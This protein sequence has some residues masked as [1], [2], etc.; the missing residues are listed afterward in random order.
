MFSRLQ[1]LISPDDYMSPT[2]RSRFSLSNISFRI[3][4]IGCVAVA[5][6]AV[7]AATYWHIQAK[8]AANAAQQNIANQIDEKRDIVSVKSL[9]LRIND[10]NFL[11]HKDQMHLT[12]HDESM[13]VISEAL[14]TIRS[15][16]ATHGLPDISGKAVN[17]RN[18]LQLYE[19]Q[20]E[21]LEIYRV[22]LGLNEN[23]GAE[24]KLRAAVREI[25]TTLNQYDYPR[26]S[27]S[28][29]MMRRHEKDF[30][31]RLRPVF[32]EE[33]DKR[34]VEFKS[35]LADTSISRNEKDALLTRL[36]TYQ[37]AFRVWMRT[38]HAVEEARELL[39]KLFSDVEP[40]L[41]DI[42]MSIKSYERQTSQK[43]EADVA[44]LAQFMW[45]VVGV[46]LVATAILV[47]LIGRSISRP[48]GQMTSAVQQLGAGQFDVE[49]PGRGR[50][51]E[52]GLMASA[53]DLFKDKL[54]A[55]A[56]A[57][58]L[59]E[60]EQQQ[61]VAAARRK[62]AHGLADSFEA[63]VG[64]I[65]AQVASLS[66]QLAAASDELARTAELSQLASGQAASSSE[67]VS[68]SA[69][70][71]ARATEEMTSSI[72]EIDRQAAHASSVSRLV[73]DKARETEV[74]GQALL[75][76]SAKITEVVDMIRAIA[77]QTNLL[78][79]NATIEAAR[80][81]EAGRG[82]AVVAS[83]VKQLATQTSAATSTIAAYVQEM[84]AA[85]QQSVVGMNLVI[86]E[87]VSISDVSAAISVAVSQQTATTSEIARDVQYVA[88]ASHTVS[89]RIAEVGHQVSSTGA[90]AEEL[91]VSARELSNGGAQL[92]SEVDHFLRVVRA[93]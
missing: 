25:E 14:E 58:A 85:A 81:G 93:A 72:A 68:S 13:K 45:L 46:S 70:S 2:M 39:D 24:G 43:T 12:K 48:L 20:L 5:G 79:L 27:V 7:V 73:T 31:L 40:L 29:L 78:A 30:M 75:V 52:L 62:E 6:M 56:R 87:I 34:V 37:N 36:S 18:K 38:A 51:D 64:S 71:V 26:L 42:D 41:N 74:R 59:R 88:Q 66:T 60:Q 49:L 82:F 90:A 65:V 69:S 19:N 67:E 15:V 28:M 61:A 80:A 86:R 17:L 54:I 76:S 57:D 92:R 33:F 47:L 8:L 84:S 3:G 1:R 10:K 9:H 22:N 16:S 89:S 4:L 50:K 11:L 55:K 35:M 32:A 21:R 23:L 91:S 44:N 83:E 53:L 63:S 77:E